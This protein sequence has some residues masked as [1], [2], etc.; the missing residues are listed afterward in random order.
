MKKQNVKYLGL[1]FITI[2]LLLSSKPLSA[3]DIFIMQDTISIRDSIIRFEFGSLLQE[4]D[5]V[6]SQDTIPQEDFVVECVFIEPL[7]SFPG[8]HS[9]MMKFI[10]EN[11]V[12]PKEA[13]EKGIEG[14][15]TLKF[16]V[17]ETGE[18]KDVSVASSVDPLL[19]QAAIDV[20]LKMPKWIPG[21]LKGKNIA[22]NYNIPINFKLPKPTSEE[23]EK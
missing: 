19:D 15:V 23:D 14:R 8:G 9:A 17:A 2:I 18:I 20:L 1:I 4:E 12:Y 5:L 6:I 10:A 3:K 16:I 11:L 7:A 13:H 22:M 21:R